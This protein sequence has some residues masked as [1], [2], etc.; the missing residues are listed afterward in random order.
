MRAPMAV[1]AREKA[2]T[3]YGVSITGIAG[4]GG[5]TDEKP[6]GTVYIAVASDKGV[7]SRKF[8]LAKD[9]EINRNRSVYAALEMLRRLILEIS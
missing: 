5:G 6:V 9:R 8:S 1:G 3:D 4:P 2:G 7:I